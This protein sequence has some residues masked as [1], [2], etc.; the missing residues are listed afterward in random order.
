MTRDE[1]EL[2]VLRSGLRPPQVVPGR[3]RLPVLVGP[4]ERDVQV[5]TREVEVVGVSAE[6]SH[7]ELRSEDQPHVLEALVLVEI[8]DSPVVQ[9]DDVA[10][11]LLV[12]AGALLLDL[13][14][15]GALRLGEPLPLEPLGGGMHPLGDVG[16]PGQLVQLDLGA[17][18]FLV[19]RRRVEAL[20]HEVL[21]LRG[22]LLDAA[23]RAMVVGHHQ[24]LGRHE[25][26]RAASGQPHGGELRLAEPLRLRAEAVLLRH[27]RA[28]EVVERPHALVGVR[29]QG[30]RGGKQEG[31]KSVHVGS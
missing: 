13:R 18:H 16:D 5:V 31:G 22:E 15:L 20:L 12:A 8:V 27:L 11:H 14:H 28:G 17:L 21:L 6:G 7:G 1:G 30:E 3:R 10:A 23:V 4:D 24:A 19:E 25:R 26:S 29:G 9:R 2:A